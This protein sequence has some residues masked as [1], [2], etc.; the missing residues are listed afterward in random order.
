MG[1]LLILTVAQAQDTLKEV[2][3]EGVAVLGQNP[4]VARDNAIRDALRKAVEQGVGAFLS[5]ETIVENFELISDKIYSSAQGYV[6]SYEVI[7]EVSDSAAGLYRVWIKAKVKL[8]D[9]QKDLE[10]IGLL[11]WQMGR[12]RIMV[13]LPQED[14]ATALEDYFVEMG[15]PTVDPSTAQKLLSRTEQEALMH[16]DKTAAMKLG[17]ATGAEIIITGKASLEVQQKK[18]PYTSDKK[19]IW[20]AK[21]RAKAVEALTGEILAVADITR[22]VPFS[23]DQAVKLASDSAAKELSGEILRKWTQRRN[24]VHLIVRGASSKKAKRLKDR[25]VQD[26]RGVKSVIERGLFNDYLILEIVSETNPQELLDQIREQA[27]SLGIV[28]K[29][30]EANRIEAV[31][32]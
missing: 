11:V 24:V 1:I 22:S 18:L 5:S 6:S 19:E 8:G 27:K 25:L 30:Y 28:V 29:G 10:A 23:Q 26:I 4:A 7:K 13:L 15:F 17:A 3:A 21:I 32:R 16:G 12:P 14:I 31:F 2:V 20:T 9:I